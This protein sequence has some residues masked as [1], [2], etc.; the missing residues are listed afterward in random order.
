MSKGG[1]VIKIE[2]SLELEQSIA[3]LYKQITETA[4]FQ[5]YFTQHYQASFV[6]FSGKTP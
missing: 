5:K 4:L 2:N 3:M 1:M 6:K